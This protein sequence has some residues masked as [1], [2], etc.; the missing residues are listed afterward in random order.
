MK[1]IAI[2][3]WWQGN[4]LGDNW[5]KKALSKIFPYA[6]FIDTSIKDFSAYDFVICGG[7]GLYIYDVISPW[8]NYDQKIPFGMI[9]LGAEFPHYSEEAKLLSRKA[10]FFLIRDQYSLDCMHIQNIERSYDVTF[11]DPLDWIEE[12]MIDMNQLYLVWRDGKELI[13]NDMFREYIQYSDVKSEWEDIIKRKFEM[14]QQDDFQTDE[15]NINER[16]DQCGFIISGRYHG[17]I[18]AIQKG[19]PFIALDICPKIRALLNEIGLDEYCIKI[20]EVDKLETLIEKAKADIKGIRE[21]E[22]L[23]RNLAGDVLK[24]QIIEVKETIVKE[25]M[26]L[27]VIHYGSYWMR[28]NDVV[29]VMADDLGELC[30]LQ[31]VDLN[32]YDK[33]IDD[34]VKTKIETPNGCICVLDA[35]KIIKDI[36]KYNADCVIMNSGGITMEDDAFLYAKNNGVI[37]VGISLSDPDVYPYNGQIYAYKFDLFYTNSKFSF[38]NQYKNSVNIK[39]MPFA[40]SINHHYYINEINRQ[41]DV[42]IVGHARKDRID[43]VRKLSHQFKIGTYGKGWENSLGIVNGKAHVEAINTGTMYLSFSKTSAGYNNVKVGLFEAIACKQVVITEYMEELEDYFD[44]GKEILCYKNVNELQNIIA[45]YIEHREEREE[46][47]ERAY[48]RFLKDHTYHR[49][50]EK[51]MYDIC[52]KKVEGE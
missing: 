21:K 26:P 6:E 17:I 35:Q 20:S 22:K 43:I 18:A 32:I 46:I 15:N 4:N 31:K 2:W 25:L 39:L 16:M 19:L 34:R 45:Y 8:K 13:R 30:D 51:V 23:Y 9:G 49:R 10:K 7:G 37:T 3:G 24:R 27:R 11:F 36:I 50:W 47:R 12:K 38:N 41:Y 44:I 33:D 1:K 29:N 14:I 5:I 52:M 28:E 42:V 48:Q 40:A